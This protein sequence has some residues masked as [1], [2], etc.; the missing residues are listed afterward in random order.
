MPNSS[1]IDAAIVQALYDDP[2]L[3]SLSEGVFMDEAPASKRRFILVSL[4]DSVDEPMF[5]DGVTPAT[6]FEEGLYLVKYVSLGA[7]G[8]SA[9]DAAARIH[10][11]LQDIPIDVDGYAWLSTV[12]EERVRMAEVDDRDP[13][14]RWHHRGGRYR[15]RMEPLS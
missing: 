5:S 3:K 12:R 15:V 6:A 4:V 7:G 2:E 10:D 1:L 14:L 9:S 8:S 11:V 13:D